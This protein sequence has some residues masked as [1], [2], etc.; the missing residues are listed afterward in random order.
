MGISLP[1]STIKELEVK[2]KRE[3]SLPKTIFVEGSTDKVLIKWFLKQ[4][5]YKDISVRCIDTVEVPKEKVE[6]LNLENNNRNR[7][8]IIT[9]LIENGVIGIIDSDFDFLQHKEQCTNKNLCKTDYANMEMYL[10]DTESLEKIFLQY[11]NKNAEEFLK[12]TDIL[13]DLFLIRY[14]KKIL[15]NELSNIDFSKE[16][17]FKSSTIIFDKNKYLKKYLKNNNELIEKFNSFINDIKTKLPKEERELINGHDFVLMLQIFLGI[18]QRDAKE[19]F[20]KSLYSVLEYDKLKY[21]KM[22]KKLLSIV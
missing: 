13:I 8:I 1:R 2:Y 17:I 7:V 22:F 4:S 15:K 10:F 5:K 12:C 6:E 21:E 19:V 20:E 3:P 9:T 16:L 18:K 11:N 14:A